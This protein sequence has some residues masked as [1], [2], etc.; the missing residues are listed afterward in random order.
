VKSLRFDPRLSLLVACLAASGCGEARIVGT[1]ARQAGSEAGSEA[2]AGSASVVLHVRATTK[3]VAH[4]DGLSGQT[5]RDEY[6]GYQGLQLM[7]SRDDPNPVTIFELPTYVE[8]R[9]NDGDDTILAR[10][11]AASLK[12]GSYSWARTFVTHARYK[13]NATVHDAGVDTAGEYETLLVLSDDTE[14]GGRKR[15]SGEAQTYFRAGGQTFGPTETTMVLPSR[16]EKGGMTFEIDRGRASYVYPV[17]LLVDPTIGADVHVTFEVNMHEC[18]R[19][20]DQQGA[21]YQPGVWD[22]TLT[23]YEPV[24][25]FQ[26]NGF[27]ILA[28]K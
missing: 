18:F 5:P 16:W 27:T 19:W 3:P 6:I 24:K 17:I 20:E 11:P 7:T 1:V 28:S 21:A 26:A 14:V 4:D 2:S 9:L 10:T 22:V 8:A 25:Q 15:K 23:G 12:A 13:V